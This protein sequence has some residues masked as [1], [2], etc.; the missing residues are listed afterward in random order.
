MQAV[1]APARAIVVRRSDKIMRHN[2]DENF[3]AA[4]GPMIAA[5]ANLRKRKFDYCGA[6]VSADVDIS[7][8]ER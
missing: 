8:G 3:G 5:R 7:I 1:L 2:L 4:A 6:L